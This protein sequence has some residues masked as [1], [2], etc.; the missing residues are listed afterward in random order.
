MGLAL[1]QGVVLIPLSFVELPNPFVKA[2]SVVKA[3]SGPLWETCTDC[4]QQ[5]LSESALKAAF[6]KW[7]L[8]SAGEEGNPG[9]EPHVSLQGGSLS[10]HPYSIDR[11]EPERLCVFVFVALVC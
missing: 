11:Q 9:A 7:Q 8:L 4:Q 10:A 2:S 6:W 1:P 5:G 3:C